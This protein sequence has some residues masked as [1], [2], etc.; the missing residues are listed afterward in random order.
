MKEKIP[1]L[2]YEAN[3]RSSSTLPIH[4]LAALPQI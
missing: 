2:I 1:Y 3:S 4:S